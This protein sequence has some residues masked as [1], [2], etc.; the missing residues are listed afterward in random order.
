MVSL[1]D[2]SP[3]SLEATQLVSE[4]PGADLPRKDDACSDAGSVVCLRCEQGGSTLDNEILLCDGQAHA[5]AT[6]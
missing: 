2:T 1:A 4:S 3:S 5:L 6:K